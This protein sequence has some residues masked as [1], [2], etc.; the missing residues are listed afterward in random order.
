[1]HTFTYVHKCCIMTS[2]PSPDLSYLLMGFFIMTI[3]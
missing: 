3:L 2:F 1:M